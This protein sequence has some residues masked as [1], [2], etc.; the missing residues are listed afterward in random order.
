[1]YQNQQQQFTEN[2]PN[3][4]QKQPHQ[5]GDNLQQY[6]EAP[7]TPQQDLGRFSATTF[8]YAFAMF[9]VVALYTMFVTIFVGSK[10]G[11]APDMQFKIQMETYEIM[12]ESGMGIS[13]S[14]AA[15]LGVF[16]YQLSRKGLLFRQDIRTPKQKKMTVKVFALML[17]FMFFANFLHDIATGVTNILFQLIG[18]PTINQESAVSSNQSLTFILYLA[19][20]GP[21]SEEFIFRGAA[22]GAFRKHGKVF[23]II[24]SSLI[25]GLFHMNFE[26][27]YFATILGI[28]LAYFALE[29]SFIWAVIFHIFNN[30]VI[31]EGSYLLALVIPE[32]YVI[33]LLLVLKLAG[34]LA[35]L[36]FLIFKWP[37][38]KQYLLENRSQPGTYRQALRSA[39]F[40]VVF[41][42]SVLSIATPYILMYIQS[43]FN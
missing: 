2:Y 25:F 14:L 27:L 16:I 36:L 42:L 31:A 23:A 18:L 32:A 5:F 33:Y 28:G 13:M 15:I 39:W 41:V 20:I 38:I 12:A 3:P 35:I 11:F 40:W 19:L 17:A 7:R 22:L 43:L 4:Y 9:G 30:L 24:F 26:Q 8:L 6:M 21:I 29:Y 34:T 1:M 10:F 37:A